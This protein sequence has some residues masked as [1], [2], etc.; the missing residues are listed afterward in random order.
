MNWLQR[1][2]TLLDRV[3]LSDTIGAGLAFLLALYLIGHLIAWA[4]R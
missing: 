3:H 4:A 2:A 1:A